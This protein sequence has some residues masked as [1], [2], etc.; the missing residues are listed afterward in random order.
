MS[1]T[2]WVAAVS[3]GLAVALLPGPAQAATATSQNLLGGLAVESW[4]ACEMPQGWVFVHHDGWTRAGAATGMRLFEGRDAS[5]VVTRTWSRYSPS[6]RVPD[7]HQCVVADFDHNG[8]SDFY[9]AAG[10][11]SNNETKVNGRGNEL[12][13]QVSS[14]VFENRA[15]AWGVEDVCGRS[16][17]AATGDFNGDGWAD[18][19]VGNAVPRAVTPDPCDA[20]PGSEDSHLYLNSGG[21]GFT[22]ATT[23]W[24]LS[25]NAGVRCAQAGQ[26]IGGPETD[27]VVCRAAG[28]RVYENVAGQGFV[29]RRA[30]LG[31][32]TTDWKQAAVGD[33]TGD[34]RPDLVAAT[35]TSVRVWTS[36]TGTPRTVLTSSAIR[37]VA[38]N[39]AG[40]I[41]VLRSA[42]DSNPQDLVLVRSG[43]TWSQA[44]VPNA[45]GS[46]DFVMWLQIADAWLVGNG[47]DNLGPMQL[48]KT[49]A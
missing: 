16:H 23:A 25:G 13:L 9:V 34:G 29:D 17:Y 36:M 18:L 12:W 35:S 31:I 4:G 22:D 24:G 5:A 28:L 14:G 19:Y 43:T 41:Y 37:G 1:R 3:V 47:L 40:D 7:R 6:G 33:V 49:T 11:G 26:F 38:V 8:L 15:P 10:R 39:P 2:S 20:T 42:S 30:S 21:A 44:W 46:G 45:A 48:V 32:P 27:L